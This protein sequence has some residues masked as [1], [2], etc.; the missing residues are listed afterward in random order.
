MLLFVFA[1]FTKKGKKRKISII[2]F[3]TVSGAALFRENRPLLYVNGHSIESCILPKI[4]LNYIS[5][6]LF[7]F[8]LLSSDVGVGVKKWLSSVRASV[9]KI[10]F[11]TPSRRHIRLS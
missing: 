6:Y 2:T 3:Q 9:P 7:S 5:V 4:H 10:V 11:T 8:N 1:N